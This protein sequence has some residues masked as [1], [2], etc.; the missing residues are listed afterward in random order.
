MCASPI[1]LARPSVDTLES[2]IMKKLNARG[3]KPRI[4]F[5]NGKAYAKE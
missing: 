2:D 3:Q 5:G 4:S 1:A